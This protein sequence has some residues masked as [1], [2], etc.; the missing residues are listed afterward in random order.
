[1]RTLIIAALL[2]AGCADRAIVRET[3]HSVSV[4]V[5]QKC[6]S[7][8]PA[9]VVPLRDRIDETAWLALSHKQRVERFA[10]QSGRRLNYEGSIEAAT[11]A[12]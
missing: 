8:K 9:A 12:C 1:M 11:S 7:E 6:A 4:P 10:A 2:L 3:I 5:I